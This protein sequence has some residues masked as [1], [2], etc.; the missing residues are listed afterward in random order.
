MV[1]TQDNNVESSSN[2]R[3]QR[4]EKLAKLKEKGIDPYPYGFER[5]HRTGEIQEKF[6]DLED[7]ER[8]EFT[9]SVCGK[10]S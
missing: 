7:G 8:T 2:L 6:K 5:T 4:L 3:D 9:A 1:K 10:S